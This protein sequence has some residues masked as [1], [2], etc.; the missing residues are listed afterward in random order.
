MYSEFRYVAILTAHACDIPVC[1]YGVLALGPSVS[2]YFFDKG[3]HGL[4]EGRRLVV[5]IEGDEVSQVMEL[6]LTDCLGS[7]LVL[8]Q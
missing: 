2:T 7:A 1:S 8:T 4:S 3:K 6:N 5:E